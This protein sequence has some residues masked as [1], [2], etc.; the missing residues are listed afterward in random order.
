LKEQGIDV[1]LSGLVAEIEE[2]DHR[3]R[4]RSVAPLKPAGDALVIDSTDLTVDQVVE[5]VLE[6]V[7]RVLPQ[8]VPGE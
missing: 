7:R 8:A 6:Q 1:N 5:R 4:N 2:R 3:D